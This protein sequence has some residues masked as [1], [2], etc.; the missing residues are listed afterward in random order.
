VGQGVSG[1]LEDLQKIVLAWGGTKV[2][3]HGMNTKAKLKLKAA[4]VAAGLSLADVASR[5]AVSTRAVADWE[6]SSRLPQNK[7]IKKRYLRLLGIGEEQTAGAG[8]GKSSG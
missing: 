3:L 2:I 4:R 7:I 8:R 5:L 1:G 6:R